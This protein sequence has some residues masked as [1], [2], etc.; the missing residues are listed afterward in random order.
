[1]IEHSTTRAASVEVVPNLLVHDGPAAIDFYCAAFGARETFIG[2]A[3]SGKSTLARKIASKSGAK[4]LELDS[5][6]HQAGWQHPV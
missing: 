5:V 6:N 2:A 3:G 4:Y 1:M